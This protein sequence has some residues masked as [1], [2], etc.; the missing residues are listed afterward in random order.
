M[1]MWHVST[2]PTAAPLEIKSMPG[3]PGKLRRNEVG[4]SKNIGKL[5]RTGFAMTCSNCNVRGH[6]KRGCSQRVESSTREEPL[7]TDKGK[8]KTSGLGRPKKAKTEG[9]H[10]TKRS[11]RRPPATPSASLGPA[12]RSRERPP[13]T[14]AKS[15]RERPPATP[16]TSA[17]PT[18]GARRRP[19]IAPATPNAF[20]TPSASAAPANSARGRPPTAPSAPLTCPSPANYHV[21]SSTPADYQSTNSNR[22]RGRGRGSTTSYK[23]QAVIGMSV[24]QAE[25]GFKA[26]NVS[27]FY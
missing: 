8:G 27:V 1:E 26:L 14:P 6:N 13:A 7:N 9:E 23:R 12:K 22:G 5:T 3:R 21:G 24:F 16:S 17:T 15:A 25:N 2:N 19:L 11:R 18:K 10:S 20:A 4:E